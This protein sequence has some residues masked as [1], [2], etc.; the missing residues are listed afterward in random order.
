MEGPSAIAL[1]CGHHFS[2]VGGLCKQ[3][4]CEARDQ[5]DERKQ[6]PYRPSRPWWHGASL[7]I[8]THATC[9]AHGRPSFVFR[10]AKVSV[11][12]AG[13]K[14]PAE[15]LS[16]AVMK[17]TEVLVELYYRPGVMGA[18]LSSPIFWLGMGLALLAGF[19]AA[20]PVNYWL[21][22]KGIRHIH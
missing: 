22:G 12:Q 5:A 18:G 16:I 20:W 7:P 15:G 21:V 11:A 9:V 3:R 19:I 13:R 1:A 17:A 8:C 10:Y 14:L 6:C 2:M 4:V